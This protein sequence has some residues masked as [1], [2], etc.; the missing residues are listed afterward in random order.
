MLRRKSR[1]G[2]ESETDNLMLASVI[3]VLFLLVIVK[4]NRIGGKLGGGLGGAGTLGGGLG[5]VADS[6]SLTLGLESVASIVRQVGVGSG[7][8]RSLATLGEKGLDLG[9][10]GLGGAGVSEL[11]ESVGLALL[12]EV[13][14]H[15]DGELLLGGGKEV[16]GAARVA[17]VEKHGQLVVVHLRLRVHT[18][19]GEGEGVLLFLGQ[20]GSREVASLKGL[21]GGDLGSS[22]GFLALGSH[23]AAMLVCCNGGE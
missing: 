1:T 21:V 22:G 4:D 15:V 20:L 16:L 5:V 23:G 6:A 12:V 17:V 11:V 3:D 14:S 18:M 13:G 2:V 19:P 9:V 8:S 7:R 10:L